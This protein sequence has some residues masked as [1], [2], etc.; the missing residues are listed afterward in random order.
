MGP[1]VAGPKIAGPDVTGLNVAVSE[2]GTKCP[3]QNVALPN[4]P[5]HLVL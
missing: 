5:L 2:G 3:A 1:N 4:C